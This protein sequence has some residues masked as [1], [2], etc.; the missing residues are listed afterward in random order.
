M[1]TEHKLEIEITFGKDNYYHVNVNGNPFKMCCNY[2]QL[3]S[4][5]GS[6][7]KSSFKREQPLNNYR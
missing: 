2:N 3:V 7:I 6:L 1:G 4:C 5:I